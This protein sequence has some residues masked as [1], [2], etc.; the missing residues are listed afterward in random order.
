MEEI[1]RERKPAY[2]DKQ[3]DK[4]RDFLERL[5]DRGD[6]ASFVVIC[7][8]A[9]GM[10]ALFGF[11][12]AQFQD[13]KKD[14]EQRVDAATDSTALSNEI[15]REYDKKFTDYLEL[16]FAPA[17]RADVSG[18][19]A[20]AK[21]LLLAREQGIQGGTQSPVSYMELRELIQLIDHLS[22]FQDNPY[23]LD[24]PP[25]PRTEDAIMTLGLAISD[26]AE[27]DYAQALD[28]CSAA[29]TLDPGLPQSPLV[30]AEIRYLRDLYKRNGAVMY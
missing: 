19:L 13:I 30:R 1:D 2:L 23:W 9:V 29:Q 20:N 25:T 24:H 17:E 8:G 3:A 16:H 14:A 12:W 4:Y 6:K 28:R 26:T 18:V 22:F 27:G 11:L 10:L 5:S 7:G 15:T 21:E